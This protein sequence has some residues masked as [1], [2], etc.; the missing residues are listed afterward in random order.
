MTG[1]SSGSRNDLGEALMASGETLK[2]EPVFSQAVEL[3]PLMPEASRGL[4]EALDQLGRSEEALDARAKRVSS[5][6]DCFVGPLR[7]H[8]FCEADDVPFRIGEE[9]DR[10]L[11]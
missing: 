10:D 1:V 6:A 2:A 8:A 7:L 4:A 5:R 3:D 9:G 11:G